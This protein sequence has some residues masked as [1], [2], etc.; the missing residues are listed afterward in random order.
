MALSISAFAFVV[1]SAV[2]PAEAAAEVP[3]GPP[4]IGDML[5]SIIPP[6]A[7]APIVGE[8]PAIVQSPPG[9][10]GT[11]PIS[12]ALYQQLL[13]SLVGDPFFDQWPA[14]LS[15]LRNGD[16]IG[17]PDD[18]TGVGQFFF[19]VLGGVSVHQLKFRTTDNDDSASFGTAS[20]VVPNAPW[21]GTGPRPLLVDEKPIDAL[22]RACTPSYTIRNGYSSA[23]SQ[24]D[25]VPPTSQVAVSR[26]YAVLIPDH[27]GP[28]MS[29]AEPVV[30]G[31]VTLD[32][33]RAVQQFDPTFTDSAMVINGYSGGAI[34][35]RGTAL[36]V[37]TYAPELARNIK[38]AVMGGNP[39][40]YEVLGWS[41]D[42]PLNLASGVFHS[43]TVGYMRSHREGFAEANNVSLWIAQSPYKD[44]CLSTAAPIGALFPTSALSNT[45]DPMGSE[46]AQQVFAEQRQMMQRPSAVPLYVFNGAQEFWVPSEP[47]RRFA[48][49]QCEQGVPVTYTEPPGEHIL[50]AL[51]AIP[52]QYTAI[53][54]ALQGGA[55]PQSNCGAF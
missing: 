21:V 18:V 39:I 28:K 38:L 17:T 40:D 41:M 31:R 1:P 25:F 53:D 32:A 23:T 35:T 44:F 33:I 14:D 5:N 30:A 46:F 54:R 47:A 7:P 50:A 42:G 9:E 48:R 16:I 12:D 24:T 11:P 27:E 34:A 22:G 19:P 8:V 52:D 45:A 10:S 26:N 3:F 4:S 37:A 2:N 51:T 36:E 20:L 13:P 29:Y 6:P 43:A 49:I 15:T 55:A